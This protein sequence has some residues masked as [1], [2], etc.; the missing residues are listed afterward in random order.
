MIRFLEECTKDDVSLVGGKGASLGELSRAGKQVPPGFSITVNAYR[1]FAASTGI[2]EVITELMAKGGGISDDILSK[3]L[4]PLLEKSKIPQVVES[5]VRGAYRKLCQRVGDEVLVA[6]RSS[7]TMEDSASTSFA[8]QHETF[9]N[10]FGE[11]NVLSKTL[12]CW[13]SMFSSQAFHY[14][15]TNEI[16]VD[17]EAMAVVVQKMV[18]AKVSGVAFTVDPV[19]GDREQV[20]IDAA[21]GLGEG[22]VGGF[23]TPDHFVVD[24]KTLE[25]KEQWISPKTMEFV[26]DPNSGETVP[27]EVPQERQ[28]ISCLTAMEIK[29]LAQT[30]I[31]IEKHYGRPQDI[32]WALDKE[33][34][35]P[36]NLLILQSR[37]VTAWDGMS[38]HDK[39]ASNHS[40][41]TV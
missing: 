22:I 36:K 16:K 13:A 35:F 12:Y 4:T 26:R 30:A 31:S 15:S 40:S 29:L 27:W 8:G 38:A 9:L 28:Q 25:I 37:P 2:K 1:Q 23:V 32:E 11:D 24:K 39:L 3:E 14:R 5:A 7:A 18:N 33:L 17:D 20:V 34:K 10:V 6:V 41:K 19:S 21:W